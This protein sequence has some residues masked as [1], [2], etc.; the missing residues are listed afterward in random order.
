MRRAVESAAT[1]SPIT[2]SKD[3]MIARFYAVA[4]ALI[5]AGVVMLCQ[6]FLWLVHVWAFPVFLVGFV[7]FMILDHLPS[8]EDRRNT[9]E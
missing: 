3:K 2:G 9:N 7:L 8:F 1:Q 6:P 4:T 5:I